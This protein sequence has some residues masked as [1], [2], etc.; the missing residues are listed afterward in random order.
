MS[1]RPFLIGLTGSIGM[2]K[3]TTA[4][5]FADEGI[6]VWDADARVREM[7]GTNGA[8]VEPM[9]GLRAETIVDDMID[10][11]ALKNWIAEDPGALAKIESVV[12]PLVTTDRK[13]FVESVTAEV[14]VLDI[15]LLFETGAERDMDAIAVVSAPFSIQRERVLQRGGISESQL[16]AL[17]ARQ[18]PDTEK[19]ARADYVIETVSLDGARAA[20]RSCLRD[21]RER[22]ANA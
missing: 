7:Y 22:L 15:P 3:T 13:E 20:V 8:A 5:M 9:R 19:R 14:A 2:G 17:L 11:S 10:R 21:V 12:H 6:P 16:D 18:M 4:L 1:R